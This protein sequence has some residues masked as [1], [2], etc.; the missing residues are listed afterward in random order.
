MGGP[1]GFSPASSFC[2]QGG[3]DRDDDTAALGSHTLLGATHLSC[4]PQK[5][6]DI[7]GSLE[8]NTEGPG[9]ASSQP[10]LPS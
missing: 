3:L 7:P 9:T 6:P 2:R 5:S 10:L 8:G 4:D 1:G